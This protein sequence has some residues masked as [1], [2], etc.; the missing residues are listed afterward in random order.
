[1]SDELTNDQ[2]EKFRRKLLELQGELKALLATTRAETRPVDL[3]APIGRLSRMDAMQQQ[4]MAKANRRGHEI[5]LQQISAALAAIDSGNYGFCKSCEEPIGY[6]RLTARP[7]TPLCLEC[8]SR[9]E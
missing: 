3:G 2:I 8:Q 1:M 6:A 7:E 9:R 4:S 5:R